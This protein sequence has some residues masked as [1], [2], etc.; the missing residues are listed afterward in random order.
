MRYNNL[1]S[2]QSG[3]SPAQP[4]VRAVGTPGLCVRV[5][6]VSAIPVWVADS[7]G[8]LDNSVDASGTPNYGFILQPMGTV[9]ES[10]VIPNVT[11]GLWARCAA[12]G[13]AV[14]ASAWENC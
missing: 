2:G 8:S 4:I 9:G 6:N 13:G 3:A 11:T 7:G 1:P 12:A 10:M 5:Q 14:E